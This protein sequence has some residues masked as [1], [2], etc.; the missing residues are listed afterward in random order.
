MANI[1][2]STKK[3]RLRN[4]LKWAGFA[5]GVALLSIVIVGIWGF[6]P[7]STAKLKEVAGQFKNNPEW[8]LE[9]ESINPARNACLQADCDQLRKV[10]GLKKEI[11]T[12]LEFQSVAKLNDK[13]M[14]IHH[15]DCTLENS[16]I[17]TIKACKASATQNGYKATVSYSKYNNEKPTVI[18]NIEK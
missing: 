2:E 6:T 5:T 8:I 10:W 9:S 14:T 12:V 7:G 17:S 13:N 4:L 15:E 11:V 3:D 1:Q 16:D 18:L